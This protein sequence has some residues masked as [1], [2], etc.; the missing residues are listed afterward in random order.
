MDPSCASRAGRVLLACYDFLIINLNI[1]D[2]IPLMLSPEQRRW[3]ADKLGDL[4]N[5]KDTYTNYH[6][7]GSYLTA[8]HRYHCHCVGII[9]ADHH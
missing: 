1:S 4:A 9:A 7:Y 5:Y 8:P 3:R 2:A 6:S